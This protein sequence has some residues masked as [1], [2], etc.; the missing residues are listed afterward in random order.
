MELEEGNLVL[1]TVDRIVGTVVFIKIDETGQEGSI[2]TAEIAP[3]RIRNL[4][5]YVV[6]KKKIVCKILKIIPNG[7]I[8]LSLRRVSQK[9]K[10]EVLE[11]YNQ[12]KSAISI[13]KSMAGEKAESILNEIK[14]KGNVL[15]FLERAKE[16]CNE[17]EKLMGKGN[18]EKIISIIKKQKNKKS[19]IKKEIHLKTTS[20]NGIELI[21]NI[22]ADFKDVEVKYLAAGRYVLKTE[23]TE[24]KKAD[25]KL[26]EMINEIEKKSKK[27]GIEFSR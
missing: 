14:K 9:E 22:F 27:L 16:N 23:S 5:D 21:K 17:L 10:K 11:Q 6:P 15:E 26:N 24:L 4:R 12:E 7:N 25:N 3:G 20:P 13:I 18:C 1:C 8:H 19:V 2:I